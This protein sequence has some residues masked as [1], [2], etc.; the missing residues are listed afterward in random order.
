MKLEH[1]EYEPVAIELGPQSGEDISWPEDAPYGFWC[2]PRTGER[3]MRLEVGDIRGSGHTAGAQ[4][5]E[6]DVLVCL[7]DFKKNAMLMKHKHD[8]LLAAHG[9]DKC[10]GTTACPLCSDSWRECSI[11][12]ANRGYLSAQRSADARVLFGDGIKNGV[13]KGILS[14]DPA[15]PVIASRPWTSTKDLLRKYGILR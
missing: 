2:A 6:G 1:E 7:V 4:L 8:M 12:D 9:L 10:G 14:F 3:L 11:D 15:I 13:L 5:N